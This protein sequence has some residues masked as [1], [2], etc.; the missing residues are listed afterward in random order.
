MAAVLWIYSSV[1]LTCDFL[2][3]RVKK[4]V[5]GGISMFILVTRFFWWLTEKEA[6]ITAAA[7]WAV[8]KFIG[9]L[10]PLKE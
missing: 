4:G 1:F 9:I 6:E 3:L 5:F 7:S 8:G 2:K 10:W